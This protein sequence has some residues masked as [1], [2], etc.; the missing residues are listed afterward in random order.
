MEP[1]PSGLRLSVH[2]ALPTA[3]PFVAKLGGDVIATVTLFLDSELGLPL[4]ALYSDH[5]DRLRE[6][7]RSLAEAGMLA[8][9]RG[10]LGRGIREQLR[11]MRPLFWKA[12]DLRVD[13]LLIAVN[14]KHVAFYERMLCFE[15]L[16]PR[17]TYS[18]VRGAPAVLLGLDLA[19][20]GPDN[21]NRPNVRHLFFREE[22]TAPPAPEWR[23]TLEELL[24]F[25]VERTG[26]L[27]RLSPRE[28]EVVAAHYPDLDLAAVLPSSE[29]AEV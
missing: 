24:Y 23:M 22:D 28:L 11:L 15:V 5:A 19:A 3:F 20:L 29:L 2:Y 4:D 1:Q 25:Y 21:V 9:R 17:R 16:G 12:I 18:A 27:S 14:P 6:A 10:L 26:M 7:G 8:D 13:N